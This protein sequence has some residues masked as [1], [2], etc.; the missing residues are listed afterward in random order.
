[1]KNNIVTMNRVNYVI[2]DYGTAVF[3]CEGNLIGN[4]ATESEA[5]EAV[6]QIE[7]NQFKG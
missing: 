5:I 2:H 3:N 4:Y 6:R 7:Q 1:M